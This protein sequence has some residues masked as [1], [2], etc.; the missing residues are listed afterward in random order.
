MC[1]VRVEYCRSPRARAPPGFRTTAAAP[2]SSHDSRGSLVLSQKRTVEK[3]KPSSSSTCP[4]H[5]CT[6]PAS[7]SHHPKHTTLPPDLLDF[8]L[9]PPN[10]V[11]GAPRHPLR[12]HPHRPTIHTIPPKPTSPPMPTTHIHPRQPHPR[13]PPRAAPRHTTPRR[14]AHRPATQ[15]TRSGRPPPHLRPSRASAAADGLESGDHAHPH[16]DPSR[17]PGPGRDTDPAPDPG[18]GPGPDTGP[19]RLQPQSKPMA[20]SPAIMATWL[21]VGCGLEG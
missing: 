21:G 1:G 20:S 17:D 2:A 10:R 19:S 18:P 6:P 16:P 3:L 5:T 8:E 14:R 9:G 7:A 4:P 13:H 15:H 12:R 11:N